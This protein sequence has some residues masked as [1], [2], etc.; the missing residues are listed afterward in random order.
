M[1]YSRE[2]VLDIFGLICNDLNL[3]RDRSVDLRIDDFVDHNHRIIFGAINNL[4]LQKDIN[5]VDGMMVDIYLKEH[6]TQYPTFKAN[7][8]VKIIDDAKVACKGR[9]FEFAYGMIKKM[10]LLRKYQL[11]GMDIREI[12]DENTL[13]I[14]QLE[15]QRVNLERATIE[16]IKQHFKLKLIEID[17]EFETKSD[18]YS[19]RAGDS[20][21][22]LIQRCKEAEH[23][24][25]T[26]QSRL[27]NAVFRG[28]QGSKYMIRSA[29]TGG[30]KTRQSIGDMC[31]IACSERYLPKMKE[32]VKNDNV[33]DVVFISTELTEDEVNLAILSTVSG[34]PEEA[35]KDGR[36]SEE[37][38]YRLR[39]ATAIIKEAKIHCEYNSNF[40]ISELENIIEKNIIRNGAKYIF[41][42]YIQ[43]TAS[44]AQELNRLF[45]YTLRE[46][47][48]LNQLSTALKNLANKYDV[49]ILTSTQLNR[50]YKVDQYLDV[51]ALRGGMATADKCDYVVIT[52]KATKA[53]LEK[54]EP[55]VEKTFKDAPTHAHHVVKNRGGK[56]VGIIIW[57]N[58]DLDTINVEDC[59]VTTQDYELV[60]S[61]S[62]ITLK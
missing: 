59:F 58:T 49:F 55:I 31:N 41:F 13:D 54:I 2:N 30:S 26:F 33:K 4:S 29:G 20:I 44:L 57:T 48:M 5:E 43:V 56:W 25:A 18:S 21:E 62:P 6:P 37:V 17:N 35:I 38:E 8:G 9:S 53:D 61:I 27:Y 32:W 19:F 7:N 24:G 50:T 23:W 10:S 36:Y 60:Y 52:M 40:N 45:G 15:T 34:V 39:R 47:Q 46:D 22:D 16:Q 1:L 28:M 11:I 51:T 14:V 3:I 12:Y 42:D